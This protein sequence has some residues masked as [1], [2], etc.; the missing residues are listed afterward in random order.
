[1]N[2]KEILEKV[3]S[4]ELTPDEAALQLKLEPF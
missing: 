1:M 3:K 2:T 4:G